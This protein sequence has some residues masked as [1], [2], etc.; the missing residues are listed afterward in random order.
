MVSCELTT[1]DTTIRKISTQPD[2][3]ERQLAKSIFAS[4][5]AFDASSTSATKVLAILGEM[6]LDR[7]HKQSNESEY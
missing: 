3:V 7:L 4:V 1:H 6:I 5:L 2:P